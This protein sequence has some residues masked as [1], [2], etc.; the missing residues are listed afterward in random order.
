MQ[1]FPTNMGDNR[2]PKKPKPSV[3]EGSTG[4][5]STDQGPSTTA[6]KDS[7]PPFNSKST[8]DTISSPPVV[9]QG[10]A[11]AYTIM[12]NVISERDPALFVQL[13]KAETRWISQAQTRW[14]SHQKNLI[15]S[16]L[17]E[18]KKLKDEEMKVLNEEIERLQNELKDEE[19]LESKGCPVY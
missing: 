1:F 12:K 4:N 9:H 14:R 3:E 19:K 17:L 15:L 10:F 2:S 18:K 7:F 13:Q 11:T 16:E 8:S 6:G 5:N